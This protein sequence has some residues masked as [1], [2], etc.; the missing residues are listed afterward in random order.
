MYPENTCLPHQIEWFPF[1]LQDIAYRE[2][3]L[4]STTM[5]VRILVQNPQAPQQNALGVVVF[6][7]L[8]PG[9]LAGIPQTFEQ[10]TRRGEHGRIRE[11]TISEVVDELQRAKAVEPSVE[12]F[13][14]NR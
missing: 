13:Q 5:Q 10:V 6:G 2:C 1:R 14:E 8:L 11:D 9:S 7:D 4:L 3:R 12:G